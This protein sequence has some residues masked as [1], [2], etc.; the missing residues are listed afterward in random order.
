MSIVV[1]SIFAR[2]AF[3][4]LALGGVM[5]CHGQGKKQFDGAESMSPRISV[6]SPMLAALRRAPDF[7][8]CYEFNKDRTAATK[9]DANGDGRPEV[10][11]W[12]GCGNS[13]TT[14]LFWMLSR[15]G[16]GFRSIF[17]TGTQIIYFRRQRHF[18]YENI[19]ARGCTANTCFYNYFSFNGRQYVRTRHVESPIE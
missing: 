13:S 7:S 5:I 19:L 8:E 10:L 18:G 11:V 4:A 6:T 2:A 9:V 14:N 16:S 3:I 17:N 1:R 15:R 12:I